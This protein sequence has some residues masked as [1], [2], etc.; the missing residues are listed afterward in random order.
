[1]NRRRDEPLRRSPATYAAAL[2]EL[3]LVHRQDQA[4]LLRQACALACATSALGRLYVAGF[5]DAP[6]AA[7]PEAARGSWVRACSEEIASAREDGFSVHPMLPRLLELPLEDWP[8][9]SR[10]VQASLELHPSHGGRLDLARARTA[11]DDPFGAIRILL[12][13]LEERP[14]E[15]IRCAALEA[16]AL[17]L[18]SA[19][20]FPSSIRCYE[21]AV[22]ERRSDLRVAV[23]LLALA[24]RCGDPSGVEL[25]SARLALLDLAVAGTRRRFDRA[26]RAAKGRAERDARAGTR[27]PNEGFRWRILEL[28]RAGPPACSEIARGLL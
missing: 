16:I 22:V 21:A 1:M 19:G 20:E 4:R 5:E 7:S 6:I 11:A 25:S 26:L 23:S 8:R 12:D 9:A 24:L 27:P 13:L 10:L 18:E 28:S 17:A 15:S 3:E 14:L 2:R